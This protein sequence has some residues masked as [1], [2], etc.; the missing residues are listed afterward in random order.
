M[1]YGGGEKNENWQ[2]SFHYRE[3]CQL[4]ITAIHCSILVKGDNRGFFT[5]K[6]GLCKTGREGGMI[7][8]K[9][10]IGTLSVRITFTGH[11]S[12]F[13]SIF[14]KICIVFLFLGEKMLKKFNF[15]ISFPLKTR[16]MVRVMDFQF[17]SFTRQ[18]HV[19]P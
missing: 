10:C 2:F 11:V 16:T 12:S 3:N 17:A 7:H 1:N 13:I 5:P 19:L 15:L 14:P 18:T 4:S 9:C 8:F 6:N